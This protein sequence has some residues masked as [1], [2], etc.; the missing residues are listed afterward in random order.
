MFKFILTVILI[1]LVLRFLARL[2]MPFMVAQVVKK[3]EQNINGNYQRA[4]RRPPG[5]IN[6]D[7]N[8]P[9]SKKK[10]TIS[11]KGGDF[12]DFEEIK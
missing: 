1:I 9:K 12:V 8:P 4:N 11:D 6:I 3:A 5:E 2:L 7:Y 10:S